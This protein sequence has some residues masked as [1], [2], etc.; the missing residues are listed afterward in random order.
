VL[1]A[2]LLLYPEV[3]KLPMS[4]IPLSYHIA[5]DPKYR[6]FFIDYIGALNRT[7]IDVYCRLEKAARYRNRKGHL[8]QNILTAYNFKIEFTYILTK[9]KGLAHDSVVYKSGLYKHGFVTPPRKY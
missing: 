7:Y 9:W 8:T 5:N 6:T 2:L 3:I 1:Q 4:N